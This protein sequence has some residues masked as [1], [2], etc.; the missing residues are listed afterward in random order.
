MTPHVDL[1]ALTNSTA[2]HVIVAQA[3]QSGK[4]QT[5]ALAEVADEIGCPESLG[6]LVRFGWVIAH[7]ALSSNKRADTMAK[8]GCRASLLPQVTEGGVWPMWQSV[9]QGERVRPRLGMGIVVQWDQ[10]ASLRY[11]HLWTGKGYLEWCRQVLG[12]KEYLYWLCGMEAEMGHYLIMRCGKCQDLRRSD[13]HQWEKLDNCKEWR[14]IE[15]MPDGMMIIQDRVEDV[16]AD[17][18]R[19][20]SGMGQHL[21][22]ELEMVKALLCDI[23]INFVVSTMGQGMYQPPCHTYWSM[24]GKGNIKKKKK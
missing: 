24:C 9:Q 23:G 13:Q 8:A 3:G 19:V 22:I 21:V 5:R 16:C 6:L 14:Y 2:T 7:L 15:E 18:D 17:L 10:R 1:L 12:D 11:I 4:G 20:L